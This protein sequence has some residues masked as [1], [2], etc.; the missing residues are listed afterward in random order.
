MRRNPKNH[1]SFCMYAFQKRHQHSEIMHSTRASCLCSAWLFD[2]RSWGEFCHKVEEDAMNNIETLHMRGLEST[3]ICSIL[4]TCMFQ[5]KHGSAVWQSI[6]DVHHMHKAD[7]ADKS[8]Q[9]LSPGAYEP[10]LTLISFHLFSNLLH[11]STGFSVIAFV[12]P[13][14]CR[15]FQL[16]CAQKQAFLHYGDKLGMDAIT[17][18]NEILKYT[19]HK[20]S[21][22]N[23]NNQSAIFSKH[24]KLTPDST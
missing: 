13:C 17:M 21:C 16:P 11:H 15:C 9:H 14:F 12:R 7:W 2:C 8:K 20:H 19:M 10:F 3:C 24:L 1:A 18:N 4:Q 5:C 23:Y 22:H 6:D